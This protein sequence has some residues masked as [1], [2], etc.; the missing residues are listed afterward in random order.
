MDEALQ[1]QLAVL[2]NEVRAAAIPEG[3]KHTAAWCFGQLPALYARFCQT[4]ESRYGEEIVRLVQGVLK[5]LA[6]SPRAYPEANK[7]AAAI[8]E[9]LRLLHEQFGLPR[10]KLKAPGVSPPRP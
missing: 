6:T 1:S 8:P 4:S 9:R 3:C 5:E 7:L 10:L 2:G